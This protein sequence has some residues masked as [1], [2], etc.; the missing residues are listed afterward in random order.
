[1]KLCNGCIGLPTEFKNLDIDLKLKI[2]SYSIPAGLARIESH[3]RALL[4]LAPSFMPFLSQFIK[5]S[6]TLGG[7][8][9]REKYHFVA[10]IQSPHRGGIYTIGGVKTY[11]E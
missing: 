10:P 3:L 9:F 6:T 4:H 11:E 7:N 8:A 5:T 1:L 2:E